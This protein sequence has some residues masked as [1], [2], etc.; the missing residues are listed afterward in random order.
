V[1]FGEKG[2][3]VVGGSDHGIVYVFDRMTGNKMLELKVAEQGMVQT[4]AVGACIMICCQADKL[5]T[6]S[7]ERVHMIVAAT[8][9]MRVPSVIKIWVYE[10]TPPATRAARTNV[11]IFDMFVNAVLLLA[12]CVVLYKYVWPGNTVRN[13]SDK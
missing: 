11:N 8:S 2:H 9:N 6:H 5:Q 10:A 1:A 3:V 4:I 7:R 12:A 13:I